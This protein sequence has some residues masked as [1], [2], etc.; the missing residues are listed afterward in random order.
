MV[1]HVGAP[2]VGFP[3]VGVEV[4]EVG[5]VVGAVVV[6]VGAVV[7]VEVGAEVVGGVVPCVLT[8]AMKKQRDRIRNGTM[9]SNK[10]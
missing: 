1:I 9:T 5:A 2:V 10:Y 8:A 7:G 4:V 6:E 3:D